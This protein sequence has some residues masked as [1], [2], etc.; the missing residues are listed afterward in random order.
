[1]PEGLRRDPKVSTRIRKR[2]LR[3]HDETPTIARR[4]AGTTT[5]ADAGESLQLIQYSP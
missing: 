2:P 1:M 3:E 4:A 5:N